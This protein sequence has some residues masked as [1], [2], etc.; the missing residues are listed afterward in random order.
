METGGYGRLFPALHFAW[1]RGAPMHWL[2]LLLALGSLLGAWKLSGWLVALLLIAALVF[3]V[4]WVL[5]W[6]A[7]NAARGHGSEARILDPDDLRRLR[8]QS[9]ARKA[10]AQADATPPV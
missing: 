10:A 7:A 3:F 8:E 5:G 6:A 9:E 2:Y 4:A 1:N